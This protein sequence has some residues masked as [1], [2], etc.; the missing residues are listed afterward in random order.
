MFGGWSSRV[1]EWY[2][3]F[4]ELNLDAPTPL[5]KR[6]ELKGNFPSKRCSHVACVFNEMMYVM[7]GYDGQVTAVPLTVDFALEL[8][9][10]NV[11]VQFE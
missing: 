4:W 9:L 5:W 10:R 3:E 7:G 2:N 11:S 1:P 6:L 8:F